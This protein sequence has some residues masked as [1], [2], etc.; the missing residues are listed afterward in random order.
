MPNR[1]LVKRTIESSTLGGSPSRSLRKQLRKAIVRNRESARAFAA[2]M[3]RYRRWISHVSFRSEW[4]EVGQ[5]DH[6]MFLTY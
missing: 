4:A 3:R 5:T 6:G 1:T 2:T